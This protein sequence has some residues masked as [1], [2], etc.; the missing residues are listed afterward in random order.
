M[1]CPYLEGRVH[2]LVAKLQ[3][4]QTC[5]AVGANYALLPK[6]FSRKQHN[7]RNSVAQNYDAGLENA[8]L[9]TRVRVCIYY[10][11]VKCRQGYC[12]AM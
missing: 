8:S 2:G 11:K 5:C 1:Y 9:G 10:S 3:P 4:Y 7:N 12:M 6:K